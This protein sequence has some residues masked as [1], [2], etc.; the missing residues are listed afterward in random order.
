MKQRSG[1]PA[2]I[3]PAYPNSQ[4]NKIV[5][6]V[7]CPYSIDAHPRSGYHPAAA[8]LTPF[9]RRI[10]ATSMA[11]AETMV[12]WKPVWIGVGLALLCVLSALHSSK[13]DRWN[14]VIVTFDTTRADHIGCYGNPRARTPN[15]DQLAEEGVLFESAFSPVPITLPSHTSIMTGK[16]PFAHGVRDNGLF[17][18]SNEQTTLAEVLKHNGYKTAAAI[19]SFPLSARFGLNQGFDLYDERLVPEYEDLQGNRTQPKR[20]L[21]FDERRA[22]QVN[23]AVI[24]WLEE[25]H[26]KPFF[27]WAH[28][29]DPHL[30]HE[31]PPPFRHLFANNLYDGEIAYAD[32]NLGVLIRHLRRLGVYDR[33]LIVFTSDHGEGLGQHSEDTHSLLVYNTTLHVPLII[34]LPNGP[35]A[36]RIKRRVGT[37]DIFPTILAEV[38]IDEPKRLQGNSLLPL[39]EDANQASDTV[40]PP[41]YAETLSPRLG[42]DAAELRAI[43]VDDHKYIHGPEPEL[44][45]L[46]RDH[47]EEY[48]LIHQKPE[49]AKRLRDMLQNYLATNAI[50]PSDAAVAIDENTASRLMALGYM[51]SVG[52][53]A[54]VG[55]E[56]LRDG[57]VHPRER[58]V[59]NNLIS[60]TK[61][62]LLRQQPL[63][64]KATIDDLLKRSPKNPAYLSLRSDAE[65]QLG[66]LDESYATLQIIY[67]TGQTI[68]APRETLRRM[69]G[70]LY[71]QGRWNEALEKVLLGEE[72]E[73][74][75]QGRY[76]A[77]VI[78]EQLGQSDKTFENLSAAVAIDPSYAPAQIDL[79][80]RL[81]RKGELDR[82]QAG[83]IRALEEQPYHPRSHYN[84]AAFLV[85][86]GN[87]SA[88][89]SHLR[90]AIRLH[91]NY[92][93]AYHSLITL[94]VES[95]DKVGALELYKTMQ[96]AAP[97]HT[98]ISATTDLLRDKKWITSGAIGPEQS[99][100]GAE[101]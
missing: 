23:E 89:A 54:E 28:Y 49:R 30:P 84:Y 62:F 27:L 78:H 36:T 34:R 46:A 94:M 57:G 95:D 77:A 7:R 81:A 14:V 58:V 82:A 96:S 70:I 56:R 17:V 75:A 55:S 100:E 33:T 87:R 71:Q 60:R 67:E 90:R 59:D 32:E 4:T 45:D 47:N 39:I 85:Q 64:A 92:A 41:Y 13:A 53:K 21:F 19:G 12:R 35:A 3:A 8:L 24:P 5:Q 25:H 86:R 76:F 80:I 37:I 61:H 93:L 48:N 72:M 65:Y 31:P 52:A 66:R 68:L 44:Y 40:P 11:A 74:S 69:A 15:L 101:S 91:P 29:F 88:A 18:V 6:Q 38:G 98:L 50:A 9:Q 16:V 2:S 20:R 83:F 63:R 1:D 22:S 51:H 26:E 79:A 97:G 42:F 99:A 10:P 43:F 73:P